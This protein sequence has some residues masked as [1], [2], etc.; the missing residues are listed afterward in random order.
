MATGDPVVVTVKEMTV[1]LTGDPL[2]PKLLVT[3]VAL[4]ALP[5]ELTALVLNC[6]VSPSGIVAPGPNSSELIPAPGEYM[7][8]SAYIVAPDTATVRSSVLLW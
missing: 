1:V 2:V 7:Q 4:L 8:T 6:A 5:R 3:A